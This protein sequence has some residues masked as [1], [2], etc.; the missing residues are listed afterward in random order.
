MDRWRRHIENF[1]TPNDEQLVGLVELY[2]TDLR[3][4]ENFDKLDLGLADFMLGAVKIYV[5]NRRR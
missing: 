5:Q 3:F 1:W 2:N 4:K